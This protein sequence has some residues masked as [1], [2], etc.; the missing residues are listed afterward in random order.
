MLNHAPFRSYVFRVS[1]VVQVIFISFPVFSEF[2]IVNGC[3][4]EHRIIALGEIRGK[5]TVTPRV[6]MECCGAYSK[7][8]ASLLVESREAQGILRE[9]SLY[10][11][12]L[13]R[14]FFFWCE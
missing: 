8:I 6:G 14:F 13:R 5:I 2:L 4:R 3:L 9:I 1:L 11:H 12:S 10:F 7:C